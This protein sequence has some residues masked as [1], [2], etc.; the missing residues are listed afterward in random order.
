MSN[1]FLASLNQGINT[2]RRIWTWYSWIYYFFFI[3]ILYAGQCKSAREIQPVS[4]KPKTQNKN[5][6][7]LLLLVIIQPVTHSAGHRGPGGLGGPRRAGS[8][9][10]S[11]FSA[12]A[13]SFFC[14]KC[15]ISWSFDLWICTNESNNTKWPLKWF[16]KVLMKIMKHKYQI[17]DKHFRINSYLTLLSFWALFYFLTDLFL[18]CTLLCMPSAVPQWD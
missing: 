1:C 6:G 17:L 15:F 2:P 4:V 18:L 9:T 5:S 8:W 14:A 10:V 3:N 11:P 16:G 7:P 13:G 12:A